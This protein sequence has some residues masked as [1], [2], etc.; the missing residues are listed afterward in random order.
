MIIL[1][2][3]GFYS[4]GN[5]YRN[6]RYRRGEHTSINHQMVGKETLTRRHAQTQTHIFV[7]I[8]IRRA[9]FFFRLP[10]SLGRF[11]QL[12]AKVQD[13]CSRY[14]I[15]GLRPMPLLGKQTCYQTTYLNV[16]TTYLR[17]HS[18]IHWHIH[19][20]VESVATSRNLIAK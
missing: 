7:Y 13:T 5:V 20:L 1:F 10:N 6:A 18:R 19:I 16:F 3:H 17:T 2:E 11:N 4:I 12:K 14:N 15:V 8:P 9:S